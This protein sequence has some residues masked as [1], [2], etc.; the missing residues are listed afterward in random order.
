MAAF[1]PTDGSRA[2]DCPMQRRVSLGGPDLLPG[3]DFREFTCAPRGFDDSSSRRC[4][5]GPS[6]RRSRSER[7][8]G[9]ISG[10]ACGA[11]RESRTAGSSGSKRPIWSSSATSGK[12][13]W[14]ETARIRCR[15]TGFPRSTNGRRRRDRAR[16]GRDRRL[17]REEPV[18]RRADQVPGSSA[19]PLLVIDARESVPRCPPRLG[20][21]RA[22]AVGWRRSALAAQRLP[23]VISRSGS[24]R[25][26]RRAHGPDCPIEEPA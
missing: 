17:S 11:R 19:T 16:C 3:Y 9:S 10:T 1:V 24:P 21:A 15:S 23:T 8:S 20:G 13:G 18:G 2:T 5:T 25:R 7:G 12:G 6:W 14:P 22:L 26:P 4:A